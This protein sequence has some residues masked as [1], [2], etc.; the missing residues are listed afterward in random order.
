MASIFTTDALDYTRPGTVL[1]DDAKLALGNAKHGY[2]K[3]F[4]K[5]VKTVCELMKYGVVPTNKK[6]LEVQIDGMKQGPQIIVPKAL[7]LADRSVVE[8]G[9]LV[10]LNK[11]LT[12]EQDESKNESTISFVKALEKKFREGSGEGF[13]RRFISRGIKKIAETVVLAD[14]AT[15]YRNVITNISSTVLEEFKSVELPKEVRFLDPEILEKLIGLEYLDLSYCEKLDLSIDTLKELNKLTLLRGVGLNVSGSMKKK[16][17]EEYHK[18]SDTDDKDLLGKK[19][20]RNGSWLSTVGWGTQKFCLMDALDISTEARASGAEE[21]AAATV[22]AIDASGVDH[23]DFINLFTNQII[24]KLNAELEDGI[25]LK[26]KED[27]TEGENIYISEKVKEVMTYLDG[28]HSDAQKF[29]K[30]YEF[31]KAKPKKDVFINLI[32]NTDEP[33][34]HNETFAQII[35]EKVSVSELK[36]SKTTVLLAFMSTAQTMGIDLSNVETLDLSDCHDIETLPRSVFSNMKNLETLNISNTKIKKL[37]DLQTGG[38]ESVLKELIARNSALE[39]LENNF[40]KQVANTL[41]KID[42]TGAVNFKKFPERII[43]CSLN[44]LR[45][46]RITSNVETKARF[47][48]FPIGFF[49]KTPSLQILD[50]HGTPI[51]NDTLKNASIGSLYTN[52]L[53]LDVRSTDISEESILFYTPTFSLGQKKD[54]EDVKPY[55]AAADSR[56][57]PT[58]AFPSHALT[59][60][61]LR[62]EGGVEEI[63]AYWGSKRPK[64]PREDHTLLDAFLRETD[65]T[66]L[67]KLAKAIMPIE[68]HEET[69]KETKIL[70]TLGGTDHLLDKD[71]LEPAKGIIPCLRGPLRRRGLMVERKRKYTTFVTSMKRD[72]PQLRSLLERLGKTPKARFLAAK[73]LAEFKTV[74]EKLISDY[75]ALFNT[76][77]LKEVAKEDLSVDAELTGFVKTLFSDTFETETLRDKTLLEVGGARVTFATATAE[78]I[79]GIAP[80][81][82][83]P[84]VAGLPTRAAIPAADAT[85]ILKHSVSVDKLGKRLSVLPSTGSKSAEARFEKAEDLKKIEV[86]APSVE[87]RTVEL[88][89]PVIP[90]AAETVVATALSVRG[91]W[92]LNREYWIAGAGALLA[93]TVP[94]AGASA[95]VLIGVVSA[96]VSAVRR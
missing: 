82:I 14:R 66:K 31:L 87:R 23:S 37:P 51:T 83:V 29:A 21:A 20:F 75:E 45:E 24:P 15:A 58:M 43:T 84:T 8:I 92:E 60:K 41:E 9:T 7:E 81:R 18:L 65:P 33:I 55:Y 1:S 88:V 68:G 4:D 5:I 57:G 32:K 40:L 47:E 49:A 22:P 48:N 13:D 94:V 61:A 50:L 63:K 25:L 79:L 72:L 74:K 59:M 39:T 86:A 73:K 6:V 42:L 2:G 53:E 69:S 19:P 70:A 93:Y 67:E 12:K 27:G 91:Q 64:D 3:N 16:I 77:A 80:D 44:A 95:F 89:T 46:L 36:I 17:S 38:V 30:I 76:P 90:A 56:R 85:P 62:E 26:R 54:G 28:A 96:V 34:A 11:V 71:K 52:L 35:K 10:E 78:Q